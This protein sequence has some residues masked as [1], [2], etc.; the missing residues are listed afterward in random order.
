[1]A[2]KDV[3]KLGAIQKS[4]RTSLREVLKSAGT[5]AEIGAYTLPTVFK[6][7]MERLDY[8]DFIDHEAL[9]ADAKNLGISPRDVVEPDLVIDEFQVKKQ[10]SDSYDLIILNHVFSH[11]V[12]PFRV[13]K[14][15]EQNLTADGR[16]VL[17]VADK[18]AGPNATRPDTSLAHLLSDYLRGGLS[19]LPEHSLEAALHYN[20]NNVTQ[21][22][23]NR[24]LNESMLRKDS[25]SY[26]PRMHVHVFQSETF[27][28]WVLKPFLALESF[29]YSIEDYHALEDYNEFIVILQKSSRPTHSAKSIQKRHYDCV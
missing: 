26:H 12:D 17:I 28:D 29:R 15:L 20:A 19:S 4:R 9:L 1:M 10:I 7:E 5:A 21:E 25:K 23:L 6:D 14:D 18:K 3:Y 16:L 11:L 2:T 13:L 27:M 8:M 22:E 24:R